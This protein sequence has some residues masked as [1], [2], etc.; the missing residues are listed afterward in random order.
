MVPV[1]LVG[2]PD[3]DGFA[4]RQIGRVEVLGEAGAEL[5]AARVVAAARRADAEF[6]HPGYGFLSERPELAEAC[7]AAGIRFVGP[8]AATLRL[9]FDKVATREAAVV[10]G[11][12]VLPASPPLGPAPEDWVAA[13]RA[14]GYPLLVKP[15]AAGGGRGLRRV[16]EEAALVAAV[17]TSAREGEAA[18]AGQAVY[19]ERELSGPRHIEV[20]L[21][22]DE[23]RVL[24]LG[25][26][27]CS[28]QR[29]HQ[30]VIEEAPAPNLTPELRRALH[31]HAEAIADGVG[32]HG[33]ATCEFLVGA[34]GTIAFLEV[35]PRIQVEHPVTE[36]V[37]GIDLVAWQ[38]RLAAGEPLP[39]AAPPG[40]RGHAIEA[41]IYAEDPTRAFLPATGRLTTVAWSFGPGVRVD[42][43]YAGGD[44]VLSAYDAMLAKVIVAAPDRATALSGLRV[45]LTETIVAG[46]PTNL[47]W[48]LDLLATSA[49]ERGVATTETAAGVPGRSPGHRPAVLGALAHTLDRSRGAGRNPWTAVGPFGSR[50]MPP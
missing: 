22:A 42:A 19:L 36:A 47:P 3:R 26:R 9:C 48:L 5:D 35:N 14:V 11:V 16:A 13:A 21:A 43:G 49:V 31:T 12:P 29:R 39:D 20:Q 34:D 41:R 32:L 17:L 18:G 46:V 50:A 33:I 23:T 25:D 1:L 30:K 27:D 44:V 15:V 4:A 24:A 6:L 10:A 8:S 38:L 28:V 45:A 7:A 40:P 37:T 2:A